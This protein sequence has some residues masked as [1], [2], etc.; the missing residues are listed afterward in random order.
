M[1][2]NQGPDFIGPFFINRL[3]V[4]IDLPGKTIRII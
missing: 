4:S 1:R 2:K 3:Q